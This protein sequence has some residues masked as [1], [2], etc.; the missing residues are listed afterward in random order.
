MRKLFDLTI[1]TLTLTTL[2]SC[3]FSEHVEKRARVL[4]SLEDKVLVL[5]KENQSLRSEIIRLNYQVKSLESKSFYLQTQLQSKSDA[6]ARKIASIK[7]KKNPNDLV[8]FDVYRW[9]PTE[10]LKIAEKEFDAKNYE[11]S[12]QF[13][14]SFMEH[15]PA[16]ESLDDKFLFQAGVASFETGKHFDW[17]EKYF[18]KLIQKYPTS[19]FYLSTKMWLAL[20]Y[21]KQEKNKEF[22]AVVEEFRKKYRNTSEWN[23]LSSHYE[24]IV[25]KYK[26]N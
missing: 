2:S 6:K 23:I 12:A 18:S 22:F 7:K 25:Q 5:T 15:F 8:K 16:S 21:L 9:K 19:D 10:M 14:S 13:F 3:G 11:K 1:L 20:S 26:S 24:K 4:N 17:S